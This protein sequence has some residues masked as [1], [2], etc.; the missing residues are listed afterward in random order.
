MSGDTDVMRLTTKE[1]QRSERTK[2]VLMLLL[3]PFLMFAV[4]C[5]LSYLSESVFKP[6]EDELVTIG[7]GNDTQEQLDYLE[8]LGATT[9]D[10]PSSDAEGGQL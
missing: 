3:I 6:N 2:H 8:G 4:W 1:E 9:G 5:T 10:A 7:M